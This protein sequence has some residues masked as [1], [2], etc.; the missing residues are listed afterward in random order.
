MEISMNRQVLRKKRIGAS[1]RKS[2]EAFTG[3]HGGNN[4]KQ[5]NHG[6]LWKSAS[7]QKERDD[8]ILAMPFSKQ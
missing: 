3:V 1:L 2:G 6:G 8:K 4:F 5:Y 7:A